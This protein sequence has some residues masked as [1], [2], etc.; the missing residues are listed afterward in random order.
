MLK[1]L[2]NTEDDVKLK[3]KT[4]VQFPIRRRFQFLHEMAILRLLFSKNRKFI[5]KEILSTIMI[6]N[7]QSIYF[8]E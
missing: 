5:R 4:R 3:C 1:P 7:V 8:N 2:G 6:S